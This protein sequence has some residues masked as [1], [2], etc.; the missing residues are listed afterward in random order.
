MILIGI[1]L[2]LWMATQPGLGHTAAFILALIGTIIIFIYG[3]KTTK[4]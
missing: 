4:K 3:D 2:L 1:A